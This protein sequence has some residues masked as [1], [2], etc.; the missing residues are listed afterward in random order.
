MAQ[1][2]TGLVCGSA[3]RTQD[4]EFTIRSMDLLWQADTQTS[5]DEI[6]ARFRSLPELRGDEEPPGL[7][8]YAH[9]AAAALYYAALYRATGSLVDVTSCSNRALNSTGFISDK[10][11]DNVNRYEIELQNQIADIA[12]LSRVGNSDRCDVIE[13]MRARAQS[14]GRA[15]LAEL[16][17]R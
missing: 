15:R 12:L 14:L 5:W 3:E 2:F 10:L 6:A 8:A 4:I 16:T 13:A 7:L 1:L 11:D 9:D 17:S